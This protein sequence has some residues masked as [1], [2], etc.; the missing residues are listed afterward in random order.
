LE[1]NNWKPNHD[2]FKSDVFCLGLTILSAVSLEPCNRIFN[3]H[4]FLIYDD[5]IRDLMDNARMQ[6][7]SLLIRFLQDMLILN[8]EKRPDFLILRKNFEEAR[9]SLSK[10]VFFL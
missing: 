2:P 10:Q 7:S 4:K 1:L 9:L 5:I 6:Y 3:Y 8:E